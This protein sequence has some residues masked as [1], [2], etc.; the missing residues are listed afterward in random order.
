M[1][2]DNNDNVEERTKVKLSLNATHPQAEK[3]WCD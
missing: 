3:K 2:Y 1:S